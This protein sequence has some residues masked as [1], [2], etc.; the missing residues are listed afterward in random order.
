MN[1]KWRV[2]RTFEVFFSLK[3]SKILV[4]SCYIMRLIFWV[5]DTSFRK[6]K[7]FSVKII[8]SRIFG[9][10]RTMKLILIIV[11]QHKINV[12][13]S[14]LYFSVA[15]FYFRAL[16][17]HFLLSE[18]TNHFLVSSV[19]SNHLIGCKQR[20]VSIKFWINVPPFLF[21]C[22]HLQNFSNANNCSQCRV[23]VFAHR[24][25][26]H[27]IIECGIKP[28]LNAQY[29]PINA[30]ECRQLI[31]TSEIVIDPMMSN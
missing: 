14:M 6:Q 11:F 17:I 9:F 15:S 26:E 13:L 23:Y 28:L 27:K 22:N 12:N 21:A 7:I 4:G 1:R 25:N 8:E 29:F 10:S 20:N 19:C 30:S 2:F 24:L 31:S 3:I 5:M 18:N 16:Y